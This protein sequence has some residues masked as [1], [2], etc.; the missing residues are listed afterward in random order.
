MKAA[1]IP[2]LFLSMCLACLANAGADSPK[3]DAAT[4]EPESV[5][6]LV[7]SEPPAAGVAAPPVGGIEDE[8]FPTSKSGKI[9]IDP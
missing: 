3:E 1:L 8:S 6:N 4:P 9:V 5:N 2:A 7:E